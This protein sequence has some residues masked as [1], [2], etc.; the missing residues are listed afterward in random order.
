MRVA[1]SATNTT[2]SREKPESA[3]RRTFRRFFVQL[4]RSL[5]LSG[6]NYRNGMLPPP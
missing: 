1:T 5:E 3:F 2:G 6:E 4:R